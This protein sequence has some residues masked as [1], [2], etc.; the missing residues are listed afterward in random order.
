AT[1]CSRRSLTRTCP[2]GA[3]AP[4][5]APRP[6]RRGGAWKPSAPAPSPRRPACGPRPRRRWARRSPR[7][8]RR[9]ATASSASSAP[10]PPSSAPPRWPS[11]SRSRSS[12]GSWA[13]CSGRPTRPTRPS[14]RSPRTSSTAGATETGGSPMPI[15][16]DGEVVVDLVLDADRTM[17][18]VRTANGEVL[19]FEK[20]AD[21]AGGA[22][23]RMGGWLKGLVAGAVLSQLGRAASALYDLAT[24]AEETENAFRAV[25]RESAAEMEAFGQ[26]TAHVA[27]QTLT[28][29]RGMSAQIGGILQGLGL[30]QRQVVEQTQGIMSL[31][32][33]LSAF[34]N[35]TISESLNAIRS[36][37]VGEQ[38]PLKRY[39]IVLREAMVTGS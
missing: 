2:G 38:E 20:A 5:S 14:A 30:S 31:A 29:F 35:T 32:A 37:L 6:P 18:G 26:A 3:S 7:T 25:F 4:P 27:G 22:L 1:P 19:K 8:P 23:Q 39:G 15:T 21:R 36:G 17:R 16:A 12:S 10:C 24:A 11:P 33:D 13:P 28:E 34:H 9:P